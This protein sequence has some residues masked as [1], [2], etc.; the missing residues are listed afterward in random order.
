M[1]SFPLLCSWQSISSAY[2]NHTDCTWIHHVFSLLLLVVASTARL[3]LE[4]SY[5]HNF[6]LLVVICLSSLQSINVHNK[7]L[8]NISTLR[9]IHLAVFSYTPPSAWSPGSFILSSIHDWQ[10][11]IKGLH[12]S[13]F[14]SSRDFDV[15]T[16]LSRA[17]TPLCH[18]H[19]VRSSQNS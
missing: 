16:S 5:I 17:R 10:A 18:S 3:K 12:Q 1:I 15:L 13:D 4:S 2:C 8:K 9:I 6:P 7:N 11:Q 14:N 19:F